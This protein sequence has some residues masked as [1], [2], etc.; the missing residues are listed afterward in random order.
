MI[1]KVYRSTLPCPPER[2]W[3][4][5]QTVEALKEL[6]P[7][8]SKVAIVGPDTAVRDG[9]LHQLR[10]VKFGLPVRWEA[11]ISE[12]QPPRQFRDTAEKS[13]FARWTHLHEFLPHPDGSELVDTIDLLPPLGPLGLIAWRLFLERDID[14]MF[15]HRHAVTRAAVSS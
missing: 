4:F 5:H 3:E 15:A 14:A 9:A 7:P 10:V 2:L 13:P 8:G 1:R 11:R 12:V 6:T